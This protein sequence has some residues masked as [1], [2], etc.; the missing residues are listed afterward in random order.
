MD[1][2]EFDAMEVKPK[3]AGWY[4]VTLYQ[5]EKLTDESPDYFREHM[6]YDGKEWDYHDYSGNCYVCF[7][8]S[9]DDT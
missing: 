9:R 7:I 1:K 2:V 8:H 3:K 6:E 5:F 4:F